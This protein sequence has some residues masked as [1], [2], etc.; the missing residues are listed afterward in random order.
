MPVEP[1]PVVEAEVEVDGYLVGPRR[2][3][4]LRYCVLAPPVVVVVVVVVVKVKEKAMEGNIVV[5]AW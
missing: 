3:V 5:Q 2:V 4:A 1:L